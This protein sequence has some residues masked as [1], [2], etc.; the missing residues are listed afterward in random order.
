MNNDESFLWIT[1][2]ISRSKFDDKQCAHSSEFLT[3]WNDVS[4]AN[5][6]YVD[7][8]RAKSLH[9]VTSRL[10]PSE[11]GREHNNNVDKVLNPKPIATPEHSDNDECVVK[12][13]K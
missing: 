13:F 8:F 3:K 5:Q 7:P 6:I 11:I 1:G 9:K 2:Q 10:L 12:V 4:A